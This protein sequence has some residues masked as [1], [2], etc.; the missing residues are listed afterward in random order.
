MTLQQAKT[1]RSGFAGWL[2]GGLWSAEVIRDTAKAESDVNKAFIRPIQD[3]LRSI[4]SMLDPDIETQFSY[5][6]D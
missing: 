2:S 6:D 1:G 4:F 3:A 5:P